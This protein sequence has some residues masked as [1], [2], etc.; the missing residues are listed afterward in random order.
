MSIA[1]SSSARGSSAQR[2]SASPRVLVLG[3]GVAGLTAAF[4]CA[5]RGALVEIVDRRNSA[6][7][8]CSFLAGGMLAP[9]CEAESADPVICDL[10]IESLDFWTRHVPVAT[11]AGSLV[12]APARDTPDLRRFARRTTH[13]RSLDGTALQGVEPDLGGRFST[14]LFFEAEA[15]LEPRHA[16]ATLHRMLSGMENVAIRFN[17]DRADESAADWII[18][19]RGFAARDRLPDLR[20]VKGEMVVLRTS[21]ISLSRPVRLVHPRYPVYIVPRPD[22]LFMIGAT[23]IENEEAGRVTA[24]GVMELLGAA[25]TLH[26]AFGDAEIVETGCDLRPAFPDNIPRVVRDARDRRRLHIN[27]LFR[28]GFL[29]SPALARQAA[30]IVFGQATGQALENDDGHPR[31]WHALA[32]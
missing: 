14:G 23:M 4:V 16:L 22:H 32:G 28:H 13:H 17:V 26:P 5:Q 1:Q 27:G 10:G 19:A 18:D 21:E 20:G 11:R 3:A 6:G 7:L 25:Y 24:R 30:E 29:L 12:L 9:W 31:E 2:P 8:G 15:H